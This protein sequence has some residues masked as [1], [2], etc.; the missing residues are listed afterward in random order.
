MA[1]GRARRLPRRPAVHLP[2]PAL[3]AAPGDSASSNSI[4]ANSSA[5]PATGR[6][7]ER[8]ARSAPRGRRRAD[9]E[10][11]RRLAEEEV[12]IGRASRPGGRATR[13]ACAASQAMREERG[14]R[15]E[16][17]AMRAC[18]CA[19]RIASGRRSSRPR[20][21]PSPAPGT[22]PVVVRLLDAD[23]TRRSRRHPR[24]QRQRQDHAPAAAARRTRARGGRPSATARACRS[25]SSTS[26]APTSTAAA[27]G[28]T[29]VQDFVA[30]GDDHVETADGRRHAIGW[31]QDFLF[32]PERAAARS[33]CCPA[34]NARACSSR[35]CSRGPATCW[36]WTN[37]RTISTS[38]PSNCSRNGMLDHG[39]T[40]L[41]VSHDREFLDRVV[42]STLAL[43]GDGRVGEYVGGY[44]GLAPAA[45]RRRDRTP[46]RRQ[47]IPMA[48]KRR[49]GPGATNV[50]GDAA[51]RR[52][53]T[54]AT[55]RSVSSNSCRRA[56][57]HW[58]PLPQQQADARRSRALSGA[59]RRSARA[60]GVAGSSRSGPRRG[61]RPLESEL[62]RADDQPIDR[63]PA[64]YA[65]RSALASNDLQHAR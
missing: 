25:R 32:T 8:A 2:R 7:T 22:E 47:C 13:A 26:I 63:R 30:D 43:E 55:R 45:S 15:R 54:P 36:C 53:E 1:R 65:P 46:R 52:R 10:F 40:V 48:A 44:S 3:R 18:P 42:T 17:S 29:T 4:A 5:T 61:L 60:E 38:R 33:P 21:S 64:P 37:R 11:D 23:R 19:R 51:L 41:V 35:A 62:E 16:R 57:K 50:R 34:A 49:R 24:P 59:R 28:G 14:H 56:S 20:A 9:A 27:E 12:W 58:R 31:L 39:G 6:A